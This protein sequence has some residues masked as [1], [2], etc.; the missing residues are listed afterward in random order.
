ML[1]KFVV[2]FILEGV[3]NEHNISQKSRVG[4]IIDTGGPNH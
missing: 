3:E 4:Q 2:L 1:P